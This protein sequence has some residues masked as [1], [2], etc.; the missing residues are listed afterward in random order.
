M[1]RAKTAK[2]KP[3]L[4]GMLLR[5]LLRWLLWLLVVALLLI[6]CLRWV[7]PP[8]S[9][10]IWQATIKAWRE[11]GPG[12]AYTWKSWDHISTHLPL[13]VVAAED[14][15]FPLHHG[16]DLIELG[17]AI[18]QGG[19]RGASTISQ[20]VVKNLFLWQG[21]SYL[22]KAIEAPLSLYIDAVWGKQRVLE[23]YLN[24]AY[25][26][27]NNYGAEA[28]S[29]AYFNK[30]AKRLNRHEAARLAATLPNPDR[31]S[32]T[33]ASQH[34]VDRQQWILRQM[35]RLGGQRYLEQITR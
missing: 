6:A 17:E 27:G 5:R 2:S 10:V 13:A 4:L 30:S 11:G 12:P 8:G 15:R 16:I 34:T 31:Y 23:V 25:F 7:D 1:A 18:R 28:A 3:S 32:A 20:Q 19:R 29:R 33:H 24:I 9:S 26:G 21:R 22:R 35:R 14:Q